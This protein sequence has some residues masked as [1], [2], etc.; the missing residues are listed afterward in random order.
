M[1]I[2]DLL[3][4]IK[5]LRGQFQD[6]ENLKDIS[7]FTDIVPVNISVIRSQNSKHTKPLPFQVYHQNKLFSHSSS[8]SK[9]NSKSITDEVSTQLPSIIKHSQS[10]A[11]GSMLEQSSLFGV[12]ENDDEVVQ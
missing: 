10:Y 11:G 1:K 9:V 6:K 3:T 8:H 4:S 5:E 7:S 12:E 2:R